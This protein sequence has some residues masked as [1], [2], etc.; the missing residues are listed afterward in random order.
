M[1]R[2]VVI[3]DVGGHADL[4]RSLLETQGADVE[5]GSLPPDTHVIQVGDLIDRGPD[6]AGCVAIAE[7]FLSSGHGQWT[8]LFGNHEGNRIG[9]RV[10]W[11]EPLD[12]G[13][14]ATIQRWWDTKEGRL[15]VGLRTEEMGDLLVT[16]GG[17]V[18]SLWNLLGRPDCEGAAVALNRFVGQDLELA[19]SSGVLLTGGV[20]GPAWAEAASELYAPWASVDEC[21]FGQVHGHSPVL[22]WPDGKA[23]RGVPRWMKKAIQGDPD[24]QHSRIDLGGRPFI[25]IDPGLGTDALGRRLRP[26]VVT[27]EILA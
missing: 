14:V 2:I 16:H 27:G 25:C 19:F 24:R 4:L 15:A 21:P 10:F 3:G 26:L 23:V 5:R 8:Q 7:R 11:D 6:S 22:D 20:P 17:L 18:R 12:D 1:S 9:A 13:S